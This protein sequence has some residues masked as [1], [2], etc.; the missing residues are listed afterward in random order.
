MAVNCS[1]FAM[2][3][4][5]VEP[6]LWH[7][8]CGRKKMKI[9]VKVTVCESAH[10]MKRPNFCPCTE[11]ASSFRRFAK[12]AV[13]NPLHMTRI[14]MNRMQLS[15]IYDVT[16]QRDR[17]SRFLRSQAMYECAYSTIDAT[18]KW[19]KVLVGVCVNYLFCYRNNQ[20]IS[21]VLVSRF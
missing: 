1:G 5:R 19:F 17:Y 7:R 10:F 6:W 4:S 12:W 13:S 8:E 14:D 15:L 3:R 9:I 2:K 21:V 16:K 18:T 20:N 11:L